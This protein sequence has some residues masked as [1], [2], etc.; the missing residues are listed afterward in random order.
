MT[1]NKKRML[2]IDG[3]NDANKKAGKWIGKFFT[4]IVGKNYNLPANAGNYGPLRGKMGVC[5]EFHQSGFGLTWALIDFAGELGKQWVRTSYL[6]DMDG[7]QGAIKE[8]VASHLTPAQM[9][10]NV[11]D[12]EDNSGTIEITGAL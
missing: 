1:K 11:W 5:V 12:G 2:T 8:E 6:V 7:N 9:F 3:A 10:A 4:P